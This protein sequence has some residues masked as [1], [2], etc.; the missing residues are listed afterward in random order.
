M[1][2][3]AQSPEDFFDALSQAIGR[4]RNCI[5]QAGEIRE[6]RDAEGRVIAFAQV[7]ARALST[8]LPPLRG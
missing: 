6:Y 7:T 8:G 4:Y 2:L 5:S 3:L 1:R